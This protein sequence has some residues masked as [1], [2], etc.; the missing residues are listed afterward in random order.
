MKKSVTSTSFGTSESPSGHLADLT[1]YEMDAIT[2]VFKSFETGLRQATILPKDLVDAMK[3]L[4]LN[5]MEQEVIGKHNAIAIE[6][7]L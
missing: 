5:P 7:I 1:D 3:M 2:R 6:N 4:G